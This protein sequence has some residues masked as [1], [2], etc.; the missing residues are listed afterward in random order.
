M[1]LNVF[2]LFLTKTY[3]IAR[4]NPPENFK[5][6]AKEVYSRIPKS[7]TDEDILKCFKKGVYKELGDYSYLS[8]VI[9]NDWMVVYKKSFIKIENVVDI[10]HQLAENTKP[11][12]E[13][14]KNEMKNWIVDVFKNYKAGE[15]KYFNRSANVIF[16]YLSENGVLKI[17]ENEINKAKESAKLKVV[18]KTKANQLKASSNDR[19]GDVNTCKNILN[20]L[21]K[22]SGNI[23][24]KILMDIESKRILLKKFF[25]KIIEFDVEIQD[26]LNF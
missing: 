7:F 19:I 20:G 18:E 14:I 10:K 6:H 15:T 22:N 4:Q 9:F 11:T 26:Y 12:D 21:L 17:D 5:E 8:A 13:E 25:D 16:K 2:T 24:A 23:E 1:E 3:E